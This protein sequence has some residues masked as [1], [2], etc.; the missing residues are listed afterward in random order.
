M[1]ERNG[2]DLLA[3]CKSAVAVIV[4]PWSTVDRCF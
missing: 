2:I 4:T 3:K 1:E